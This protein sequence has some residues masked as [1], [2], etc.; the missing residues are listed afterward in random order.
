MSGK[1]KRGSKSRYFCSP[2]AQN[3]KKNTSDY[4]SDRKLL[5]RI[6][7]YL[8]EC[9]DNVVDIDDMAVTLQAE[10][11][12]YTR[13]KRLPF[14]AVV[15]KAYSTIPANDGCA[16]TDEQGPDEWLERRE[17]E[18]MLRRLN[19]ATF[20]GEEPLSGESESS[21]SDSEAEM[22]VTDN[23]NMMNNSIIQLY[24]SNAGT[25]QT[26]TNERP[27]H[28]QL[29]P[30]QVT[31]TSQP[32]NVVMAPAQ[33][34]EHSL[35][36]NKTE[37]LHVPKAEDAN[38][39]L[40]GISEVLTVQDPNLR[41]GSISKPT[42]PNDKEKSFAK[43]KSEPRMKR[44][45]RSLDEIA[46]GDRPRRKRAK[47]KGES[48]NKDPTSVVQGELEEKHKQNF[49]VST[50]SVSFSD[51]GGCGGVLEEVCR[52]LLHLRHPEL[53]S[54]LGVRPP[55]GFLLHGPPGCG[56]TL[57]AHA[58]AGELGLPFIKL[59]A[60]EVVSGVSGE[61]EATLRDLF[62][63]AKEHAPCVLFVDEVDAICPKRETAHREMERRIV[64]QLLASLDD[65]NQSDDG[66]QVLV[67]GATSRVD[68]LDPALRRSGRFDREVCLGIPSLQGRESIL[69]LHCST[70][71]LEEDF[72]YTLVSQACPGFVGADLVALVREASLCA[73][74]RVL[75]LSQLAETTPTN[76]APGLLGIIKNASPFPDSMLAATYITQSDFNE[77][78][79]SVQPSAKREGFVTVPD[80]TWE[81]VGALEDVRDELTMAILAPVR[82]PD[83]FAQLGL[84]SPPGVLLA[85][86]P[87]CGKTLLAKAIANE[88]GIN[89]ISVKGPELLNMYVG[90]SER[91]VR[92]VFQRARN[93]APCVIFFD[94]LD[95]L[96]P[97]RSDMAESNASARVVNQLLT[98]MDGLES[99]K[100]VFVMGATN[101]PDIIDP[102]VLRPGRLD[103]IL[104]VGLPTAKDREAILKTITKGG[105][106][107]RLSS[108]VDLGQ[109]ASDDFCKGFSGADLSAL[110][111]EAA[112]V[113]LRQHMKL[114]S[115]ILP[116]IAPYI[117][118]NMAV[119]MS[120]FKAA[121]TKFRPS[122]SAK[123]LR[124]QYFLLF[125]PIISGLLFPSTQDCLF[126]QQMAARFTVIE[127][128]PR[129]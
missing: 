65:L 88:T 127:D 109:L 81:D 52:L 11:P 64:T 23:F 43:P 67:I 80:T 3:G 27:D 121:L 107:P 4:C 126:Y 119:W 114:G 36:A 77:A 78:L 89:F 42:V 116:N 103:K 8:E 29:S 26:S 99:R 86:P 7:Q 53:F 61:S 83:Q 71:R 79:K 13:K 69:R 45:R 24:G 38:H 118:P 35:I 31:S 30:D 73:I 91:A 58:I 120:H 47:A 50:S 104:Y 124:S 25:P 49:K 56:K 110:V 122:V 48:S 96:C 20:D 113:A 85:G 34:A 44:G 54:R 62:Q 10:Y 1:K 84:T 129:I 28:M 6:K 125:W 68:T 2:S 94:E 17:R 51:V 74:N 102:A 97:K 16:V 33:S 59:A 87:G 105:T 39:T 19:G 9:S 76:G 111:R 18:H 100:Q 37:V 90:E 22:E 75:T 112:I 101:R 92:Q 46:D 15:A 60:T 123:G 70:L 108:D 40:S 72:N 95:A 98:E 117:N 41:I 5:P 21:Y 63:L 57:L 32:Q 106:R 14:R 115:A 128:P 55:Q 12:E 82:Y 93:S 66:R